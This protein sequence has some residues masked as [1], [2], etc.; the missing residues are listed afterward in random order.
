MLKNK[1][2]VD[3]SYAAR[4]GGPITPDYCLFMTLRYLAGAKYPDLSNSCKASVAA[5]YDAI[6]RTM[7]AI[8]ECE[9]LQILFPS[10]IEECNDLASDFRDISYKSAISNCVGAID[11]FLL[12]IKTPSRGEVGNVASYFSGHYKRMGLNVQA[13]CDSKCRFLFVSASSP[14]SSNDRAAYKSCRID[15]MVEQLPMDFVILADAAYEPSEHCIPMYYGSQKKT[16]KYDNYNFF[17]SQL[18]IRIEMCFGMMTRKFLILDAPVQTLVRKTILMVQVIARLHN[19]CINERLRVDPYA[20]A[21]A[22]QKRQKKL[23]TLPSVPMDEDGYP[24]ELE[25]EKGMYRTHGHSIT[26]E[27]MATNIANRGLHRK[28]NERLQERNQRNIE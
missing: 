16:P 19:Y 3:P 12:P 22:C 7:I 5:V 18:R 1:L 25:H 21:R 26:R 28:D 10:S 8:T 15:E 4:R 20:I 2:E 13:I 9:E 27:I 6:T 11:G 23:R 14:G 17:A 24:I